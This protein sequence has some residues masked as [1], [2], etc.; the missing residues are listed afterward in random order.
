MDRRMHALHPAMPGLPGSGSP[1]KNII[2]VWKNIAA[3]RGGSEWPRTPSSYFRLSFQL[4]E[5]RHK[6]SH[7]QRGVTWVWASGLTLS[8]RKQK[9]IFFLLEKVFP[10]A[11]FR[12]KVVTAEHRGFLSSI[13]LRATQY[14]EFMKMT[15]SVASQMIRRFQ[16]ILTP[17]NLPF[18]SIISLK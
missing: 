2:S 16:Q 11:P 8:Q 5:I 13:K 1:G 14:S 15:C 18:R 17:L 9:I 10:F 4:K 6:C 12:R 3:L 7:W